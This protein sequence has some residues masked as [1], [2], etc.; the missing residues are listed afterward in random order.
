MSALPKELKVRITADTNGL[1]GALNGICNDI[2][3]VGKDF[4]GSMN[5]V[6]A[7]SVATGKDLQSLEELAKQMGAT[8]KFSASESA[9]ALSYMGMA[10]WKTQDM[11]SGLPGVLN[12]A[13]AGGTDL[14][15]TSDIVTD[16][17]TAMGLTAKDT[18]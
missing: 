15:L 7:I 6:S 5:K 10:G 2:S 3:Y 4:E 18:D 16:G 11:I 13:A 17:L 12:L 14:A 8:T 1:K 9:D